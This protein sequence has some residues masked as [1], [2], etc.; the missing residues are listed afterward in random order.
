[1]PQRRNTFLQYVQYV[2]RQI[3][4]SKAYIAKAR[5]ASV[6]IKMISKKNENNKAGK[7][8]RIAVISY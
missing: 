2:C 1:M 8:L 7:V 6:H 5:H 4:I 3:Y